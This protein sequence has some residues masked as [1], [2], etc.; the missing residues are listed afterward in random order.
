MSYKCVY[1]IPLNYELYHIILY[2]IIYVVE[3]TYYYLHYF[4]H[5]IFTYLQYSMGTRYTESSCVE[6]VLWSY[7]LM[8]LCDVEFILSI[9]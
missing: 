5:Y 4:Y 2:I 1:D 9:I 3:Y 7:R 6:L 8:L